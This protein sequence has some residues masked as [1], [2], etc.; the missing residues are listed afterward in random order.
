VNLSVRQHRALSLLALTFLILSLTAQISIAS[1]QALHSRGTVQPFPQPVFGAEELRLGVNAALEQY[2]DHTLDAHLS[3]LAARGIRALR[4]EFRWSALEPARGRFAWA[5]SDRILQAAARH[6]LSVLPVLWTTPAWARA[7]SASARFPPTETA[8]PAD[9]EDFARFVGAFAR[10]YGH[11]KTADGRPLLLGY[12]IWDEPNLSAAWGNALIDPT[13]YLQ[14]LRAARAAIR[15]FDPHA[16]IVL[17]GLAPTVEQSNVNLAPQTFLLKLYQ[18]GGHEAFEIAAA[19]AYGFDFPPDD[20]RV[21]AS[22]LNFSHV[23]LL[24]E[25]MVAHNDGHKAIWITQFGWNALP[26]GWRGEPSIWGQVSEAQQAEYVLRAVERAAHEWPWA[27]AMFL[28]G[29]QP[30]PRPQRPEADAQWGFALIDQAGK[31]R[32]AYQA[33][34]QAVSIAAQA[35][36]A[37]LFANCRYAQSLY[38]TLNLENVMTA[39]PE[40]LASKPDCAAPNPRATFS[41]GWRFGQLGA[42]IPDQPGAKVTFTFTGDA[43]ALIVRRG[44]YRAYTFVEIDGQPA[45]RLPRE[46]RGAYLIMTSPGLYPVIETITVA[47]GLGKGQHTATITVDRG[48]NQWALIG[49]SSKHTDSTPWELLRGLAMLISGLSVT[50]LIVSVPR[51]QWGAW[52]RAQVAQARDPLAGQARWRARAAIAGLLLW[53]TAALTW[54]QDAATAY[55][56]LNLGPQVVLSGLASGVLFWSPAT[57]TSLLALIALAALVLLRLELGLMLVAFFI[58]FYLLPQR[59]FER[60]FAM[61]ELLLLLCVISWAAHWIWRLRAEPRLPRPQLTLIDWSIAGL[62]IIALLSALQADFQVEAFR[63]WRLVIVEPAL[64]YLML[65]ASPSA[66]GDRSPNL[67]LLLDAFLLGAT[68]VAVIGLVNYAQGNVIEA[69]LGLPRIKSVFGSPNND[70]LFLER[71]LPLL[72][73]SVV[74]AA[75]RNLRWFAHLAALVPVSLA[76]LLTQSRG[77]LLLGLP[78]MVITMA[79]LAGRRWRWLGIALLLIVGLGF[80][81]LLSGAAQE[82]LAGTRLASAL[83]LQRGT[84]FFRLNLW[85]SALAMWRDHTL[86]GVGPDNFLYAYRSFYILPAA[87]QEPNLSHPHNVILDFAARLG[88]LGLI[89]GI[90]MV[91]GYIVQ[92]KRTMPVNRPLAL[93][94]AGLLAAMLSHGLVDHSFFLIE[95]SYPFMLT[96]GV[97]SATPAAK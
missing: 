38:R 68:T 39:M 71:A 64:L 97:M 73:A 54:A 90:G 81:A 65:R 93:G 4:Q 59:L 28:E 3:G 55:R 72:L 8:P 61:V 16:R 60:S 76:L 89:V 75:R 80:L 12:Q 87:W 35:P 1:A 21:D 56:A 23:I 84:G 42:D 83:D 66:K 67:A 25:M 27:G 86:L 63:E 10:R 69:E 34:A 48:W 41:P 17:A 96:A 5:S 53:L 51:A 7:P 45:N 74:L 79:M 44:N 49:W 15:T 11:L 62:V 88:A 47:D 94:C 19:K 6:G 82:A 22:V 30:R 32:P 77:A 40:V 18:L 33:L 31:P 29:L 52:W 78:A 95:L 58:P 70:A 20:R 24:R 36:R 92:I 50:G 57:T 2:D 26:A 37:Q 14:L 85:Q 91:L 43:L 9:P 46:P 13:Y